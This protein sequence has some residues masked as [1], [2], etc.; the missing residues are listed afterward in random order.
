MNQWASFLVLTPP[1]RVVL[2][3]R[4]WVAPSS[5]TIPM[6]T[7]CFQSLARRSEGFPSHKGRSW[8]K[9]GVGG[10]GSGAA[11]DERGFE[12]QLQWLCNFKNEIGALDRLHTVVGVARIWLF[13]RLRTKSKSKH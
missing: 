7:V 10:L 13:E 5:R 4:V 3:T 9:K 11:A 6:F 12:A 2:S 8:V 1:A